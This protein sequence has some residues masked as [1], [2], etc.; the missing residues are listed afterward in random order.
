MKII[1]Q[2]DDFEF[3][4]K[5]YEGPNDPE[6]DMWKW[7]LGDNGVLYCQSTDFIFHPEWMTLGHSPMAATKLSIKDMKKIV[8]EFG[9]LVVFT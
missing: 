4:D 1:K 6:K 2:F 9:H 5:V 7:G 8:K 3:F